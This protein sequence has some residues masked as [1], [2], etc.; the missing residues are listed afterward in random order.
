MTPP[1][2]PGSYILPYMVASV[3]IVTCLIAIA[4]SVRLTAAEYTR[5]RKYR[6]LR[7]A[8]R[9]ALGQVA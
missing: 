5:L 4:G 9:S 7:Q 6:Q 3:E 8:L 1:E 2:R